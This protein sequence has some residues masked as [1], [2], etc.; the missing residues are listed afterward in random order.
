[1]ENKEVRHTTL[2]SKKGEN[3]WKNKYNLKTDH[4]LNLLKQMINNKPKT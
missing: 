1:M 3:A 4:I 2:W